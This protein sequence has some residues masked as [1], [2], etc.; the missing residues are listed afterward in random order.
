M[1]ASAQ[2]ILVPMRTRTRPSARAVQ[3]AILA[4]FLVVSLTLL[5]LAIA[6]QARTGGPLPPSPWATSVS[7]QAIQ[8]LLP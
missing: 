3:L 7:P 8:G 2:A 6:Q 5:G 4:V 1:S